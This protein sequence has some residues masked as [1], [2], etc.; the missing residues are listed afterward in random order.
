MARRNTQTR[1]KLEIPK[2]QVFISYHDCDAD[3]QYKDRFTDLL[4]G[5]IVDKSVKDEDI[6]DTNLPVSRVRQIIR[7]CFIAEAKVTVVLVGCCTWQR[8]HVDWEIGSSLRKTKKNPRC[9]LV[10]I[11]LKSHPQ[12]GTSEIDPRLLPPKLAINL[13]GGA[14]YARL[15]NWPEKRGTRRFRRW[16]DEA[17]QR[18]EGANPTIGNDQFKE[19]RTSE[20]LEGWKSG[21]RVP[22]TVDIF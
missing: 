22:K 3:R 1:S 10:G 9:G 12:Y 6:D 16:I 4:E 15:Y 17:F 8:K 21:P 11:L 2:H 13:V 19:N 5:H 7:D 20:C 14:P 18:I